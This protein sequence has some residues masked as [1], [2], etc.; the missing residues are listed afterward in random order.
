MTTTGLGGLRVAVTA[1]RRAEEQV[2]LVRA[3]GGEPLL[4]PTAQVVWEEEPVAADGWLST[5][6][7]GIDDCVFMT[8]MGAE[9]L[10]GHAAA[11]GRLDAAVEALQRSRV[12]V[13]GSKAQPLL[14]RHGVAVDLAPRP[15][16][17]AGIVAAMG[18][19]LAGHSVLVQLAEPEPA[20]LPR[21]LRAAGAQVVAVCLYRYPPSTVATARG[22]DA[23]IDA[24]L[25]R[26]V[27]AVTFTS[28]PA[29]EGMVAAAAA[30]GVWPEVRRG[31]GDLLVA[32][33]GPVTAAALARRGVAVHVQPAEPRTGP[34]MRELAAAA[35]S[36]PR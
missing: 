15:P 30:R 7:G 14:R 5:L 3:L 35:A 21:E 8:G 1:Q 32:A 17:T 28:T 36:A 11:A 29:V 22:G 12:V 33:V 24:V 6:L 2:A 34:M 20:A 13:R 26:R 25:E 10:L 9:R 23:L 18:A 19:E 4:C 27:D 31:L 16:T